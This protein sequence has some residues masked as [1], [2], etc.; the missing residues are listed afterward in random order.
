[1]QLKQLLEKRFPNKLDITGEVAESGT[2][3]VVLPQPD[4]VLH[5]KKDGAGYVDTEEKIKAICEGIKKHLKIK[6]PKSSVVTKKLLLKKEQQGHA[7]PK[8]EARPEVKLEAKPEARPE[9]KVEAK[10]EVEAE[11]TEGTLK[12][13]PDSPEMEKKAEVLLLTE[14]T[15]DLETPVPSM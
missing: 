10:P 13:S 7:S 8:P 15:N 14:T 4:I 5:S 6:S 2:F 12:D 1:M 11:L 3:E 9:M